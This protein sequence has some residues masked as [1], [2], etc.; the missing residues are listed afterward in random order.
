M[1]EC[2]NCKSTDIRIYQGHYICWGECNG[3]LLDS[4]DP[5][6]RR[7]E[8]ERRGALVAQGEEAMGSFGSRLVL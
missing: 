7:V 4:V 8:A 6:T 2:P 5:E 3:R 1:E